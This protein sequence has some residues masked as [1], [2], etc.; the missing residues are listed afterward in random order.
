[1][2]Y[3]CS[4]IVSH[5]PLDLIYVD[6]WGPTLDSFGRKDYYVSFIDYFSKFTWIYL[7]RHHS[8]VLNIFHQFQAL[9]ERR[10][11]QKIITSQSDW[12]GEYEHIHYFF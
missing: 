10:F 9:I 6:V 7:I 1:L 11:G 12:G 8:K 2:P 4:T 3:S 5:H